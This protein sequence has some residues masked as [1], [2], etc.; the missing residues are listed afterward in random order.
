MDLN[1]SFTKLFFFFF[2]IYFSFCSFFP[3]EDVNCFVLN[4]KIFLLFISICFPVSN[5]LR[6]SLKNKSTFVQWPG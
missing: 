5:K 3:F 4:A 6:Y 1:I 2:S